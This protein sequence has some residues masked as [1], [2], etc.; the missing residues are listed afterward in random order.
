MSVNANLFRLNGKYMYV[1]LGIY[2]WVVH[3]IVCTGQTSHH[4]VWSVISVS[5]KRH[6]FK[7]LFRQSN[8]QIYKHTNRLILRK[9][10]KLNPTKIKYFTVNTSYMSY[11]F[12][13]ISNS[14]LLNSLVRQLLLTKYTYYFDPAFVSWPAFYDLE[15]QGNHAAHWRLG[16]VENSIRRK[17]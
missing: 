5:F 1:I 17:V 4:G 13:N 6:I 10:W 16:E 11:L 8:P 14:Y 15:S 7:S 3:V 2:Y 12:S 9:P